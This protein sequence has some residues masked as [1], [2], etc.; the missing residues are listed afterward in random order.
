MPELP[1]K[2]WYPQDWM[3]DPKLSMC[4]PATRGIWADALNVM[5][6]LGTCKIE[7]DDAKL[8]RLLR[9]SEGQISVAHAELK[10]TGTADTRI[11]NGT[12]IWESRRLSRELHIKDIRR[13]AVNKRW[14]KPDTNALQDVDTNRHTNDHTSSASASVSASLCENNHTRG[15]CKGEDDLPDDFKAF[16]QDYPKKVGK[17]SALKAWSKARLPPIEKILQAITEQKSSEQWRKNGGEFIPHPATWINAGRWDD[18]VRVEEEANC[19]KCK[20]PVSK[21]MCDNEDKPL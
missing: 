9:A 13:E 2:K 8:S 18:V 20:W 16:W 4:S 21:C 1:W 6:L 11:Q 19:P 10:E 17:L 15:G 14:Y 7:G 12:K 5:M 3:S